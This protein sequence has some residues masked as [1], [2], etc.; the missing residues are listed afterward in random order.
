MIYFIQQL[1]ADN[2]IKI[3]YTRKEKNI[4]NR[5]SNL[6]MCTPYK[7]QI[8]GIMN[9]SPEEECDLQ[10]RF[11]KSHLSG[12]WFLPSTDILKFIEDNAIIPEI[13]QEGLPKPGRKQGISHNAPARGAKL[14]RFATPLTTEECEAWDWLYSIE[15]LERLEWLTEKRKNDL[16]N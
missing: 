3:G 15:P 8:L 4:H 12:E 7:L 1:V 5:L 13:P 14:I 16:R 2:P 11:R 6:Q 10:K 9:G